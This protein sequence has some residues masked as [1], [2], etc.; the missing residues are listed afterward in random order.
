VLL[1][2]IFGGWNEFPLYDLARSGNRYD[3]G[4]LLGAG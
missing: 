2:H 1:V 4:F 3:F